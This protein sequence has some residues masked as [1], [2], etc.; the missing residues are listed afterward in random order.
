MYLDP[1]LPRYKEY[2]GTGLPWIEG[3][4]ADPGRRRSEDYI[5]ERVLWIRNNAPFIR[6]C[7]LRTP[8]AFDARTMG[9]VIERLVKDAGEYLSLFGLS[10]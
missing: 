9:V 6:A 5:D 1:L 10:S 4:R 3:A 7:R 8:T 2:V